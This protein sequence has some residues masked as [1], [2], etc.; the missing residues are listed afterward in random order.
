M[1]RRRGLWCWWEVGGTALRESRGTY[2][3]SCSVFATVYVVK[4]NSNPL[5]DAS[6]P[7]FACPD[8]DDDVSAVGE[9][10]VERQG[11]ILSCLVV[12]DV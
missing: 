5:L 2:M 8:H 9:G 7:L 11:D 6:W 12:A 4:L 10:P 3:L 1:R